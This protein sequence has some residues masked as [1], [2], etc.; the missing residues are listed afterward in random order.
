GPW[1]IVTLRRL[2]DGRFADRRIWADALLGLVV[3]L[4]SLLLRQTCTLANQVLGVPVSGLNDFD[5]GQNLL[6]HFGLRYKFAVFVSAL[7]LA[8]LESLLVLALVIALKRAT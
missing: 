2:L 5:P 8:V 4:G 3:G 6:D 7:L 1:S